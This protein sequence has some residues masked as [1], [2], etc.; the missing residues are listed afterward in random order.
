MLFTFLEISLWTMAYLIHTIYTPKP[1]FNRFKSSAFFEKL[2]LQRRKGIIVSD[3][4]KVTM[5]SCFFLVA[6]IL[7][8]GYL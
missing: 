8:Q 7:W 4:Q 5:R 1:V 2:K 6:T 3:A